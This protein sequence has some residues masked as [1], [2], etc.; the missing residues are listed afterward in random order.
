MR[1]GSA[2]ATPAVIR[3]MAVVRRLGSSNQI[4][5]RPTISTR[6]LNRLTPWRVQKATRRDAS[7]AVTAPMALVSPQPTSGTSTANATVSNSLRPFSGVTP[8]RVTPKTCRDPPLPLKSIAPAGTLP[9]SQAR[10]R[11][12]LFRDGRLVVAFARRP[13]LEHGEGVVK[14]L[15]G[16]HRSLHP[17]RR[18]G[19]VALAA[20]DHRQ[21]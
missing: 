11:P 15:Q 21:V 9:P 17:R 5:K 10:R 8:S 4:D 18:R 12:R 20:G 16:R 14:A 6:A 19:H 13:R 2:T 1:R 7:E 3:P